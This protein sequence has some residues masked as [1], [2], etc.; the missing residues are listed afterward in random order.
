MAWRYSAFR[1]K[2]IGAN[3]ESRFTCE[4]VVKFALPAIRVKRK[5]DIATEHDDLGQNNHI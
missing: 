4:Q 1:Q 3:I 2:E 5:N